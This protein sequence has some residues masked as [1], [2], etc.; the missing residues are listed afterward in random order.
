MRSRC[1]KVTCACLTCLA[2]NLS[3]FHAPQME[4]EP[5][6]RSYRCCLCLHP[7]PLAL[8][9]LIQDDQTSDLQHLCFLVW[10]CSLAMASVAGCKYLDIIPSGTDWPEQ[11][12]YP[13]SLSLGWDYSE[14]VLPGSQ[15]ALWDEALVV[16]SSWLCK[17]SFV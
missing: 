5:E 2:P 10:G 3:W 7:H 11:K 12:K 4:A 15:L 13:C 1:T 8:P 17:T 9:L 16:Q 6:R 14:G